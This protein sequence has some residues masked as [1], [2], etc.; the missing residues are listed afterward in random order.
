MGQPLDSPAQQLP[1]GLRALPAPRRADGVVGRNG[2]ALASVPM[3]RRWCVAE[4]SGLCVWAASA[5][6][7]I[8]DGC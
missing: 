1:L 8:A 5:E 6:Q 7:T 2:A 4:L 3:W